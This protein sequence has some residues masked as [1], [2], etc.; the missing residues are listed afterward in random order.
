M[1][2]KL[3]S[4]CRITRDDFDD[5]NAMCNHEGAEEIDIT[6]TKELMGIDNQERITRKS[7]AP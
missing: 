7:E 4:G 1:E 6:R 2:N 5:V 3:C